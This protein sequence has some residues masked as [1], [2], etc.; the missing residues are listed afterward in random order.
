VD[1][2]SA[3][4]VS[5]YTFKTVTNN[6]AIAA[7]FAAGP[8]LTSISVAPSSASVAV[9]KTQQF[10]ATAKDQSGNAM[11]PQPSF[12]WTVSGGGTITASGLFTA[13][14][15]A[16]GPYTV[17]AT[18]GSVS[19]TAGVTVTAA[20]SFTIGETSILSMADGGNGNMLLTQQVSLGKTATILSLS[21]YVT[22]ASGYLQL[23]IYDATGPN[24]SPGTLKAATASFKPVG[25]WNTANVTSKVSLPAGTYWLAY[26]PSSNSLGFK[27]ALTGS[28][29]FYSY[30]E[31]MPGTFSKSPMSATAHW[32]FYATL[33]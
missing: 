31:S 15:T 33:Q 12:S 32:S 13:G 26:L 19:G 11:V 22:T 8:I 25:G 5:P 20:S 9:S 4:T 2:N 3:G 21:F 10:T 7:G 30:T 16:G 29:K 17:T 18:S 14:S 1:G 24:G 27:V 23:G 28:T 6:H